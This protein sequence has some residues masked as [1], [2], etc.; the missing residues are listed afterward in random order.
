MI[1]CY[2]VALAVD[3]A[4]AVAVA[5][6]VADVASGSDGSVPIPKQT[7]DSRGRQPE[8]CPKSSTAAL[9]AF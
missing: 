6:A 7:A 3:V 8:V 9:I 2:C 4:L 1:L 5:V